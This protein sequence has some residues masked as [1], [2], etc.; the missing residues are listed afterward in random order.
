M[1]KFMRFICGEPASDIFPTDFGFTVIDVNKRNK[2]TL[3]QRDK[4]ILSIYEKDGMQYCECHWSEY[5]LKEYAKRKRN[6]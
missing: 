4:L 6:K 1:E 3:W 5:W 2:V